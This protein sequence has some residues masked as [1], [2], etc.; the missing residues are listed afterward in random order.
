MYSVNGID[1]PSSQYKELRD[2][3]NLE[4]DDERIAFS[5][6]ALHPYDNKDLWN[7]NGVACYKALYEKGLIGGTPVMNGFLFD[8]V[9]TQAGIDFIHD[10]RKVRRREWLRSY[11]PSIIAALLGVGGTIAGVLLGWH[12][13]T[14]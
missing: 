7:P 14:L 1:L 11:L 3:V 12:L 9:V 6:K 4:S 8:G 5:N 2:L 10:V 13:G